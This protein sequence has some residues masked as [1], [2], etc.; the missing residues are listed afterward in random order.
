MRTTAPAWRKTYVVT[1]ST[2]AVGAAVA[3]QLT[4][5]GHDVRGLSRHT[6]ISI[7]DPIALAAAFHGADGAFLMIPFDKKAPNLHQREAEIATELAHAVTIA[8][9]RR[10]V[11]LSG[12]SAHL[13][14]KAGSGMGAAIGEQLLDQIDIPERVYLRA[15]FFM[16]NHLGFGF[17][18]QAA[19]SH[20]YA[21]MFRPDLATPMIAAK[22]VGRVAAA[23]LTEEP[24]TQPRMR[25]LLGARDY[26]MTE[27]TRILGTAVDL[28]RLRYT[29]IPYDQAR[30]SMIDQGLSGSF[31]DAVIETAHSFNDGI[32][33]ATQPQS[34]NN[35]TPTTLE[36][37]ARD[38]VRPVYVTAYPPTTD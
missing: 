38:V 20:T 9:T 26:T 13:G 28:P 36:D 16:E 22:D 1:G 29:Q 6:G 10:V 24:F 18:D 4:R 5:T 34:A 31:A 11:L 8:R 23:L 35:S 12:T 17:V 21:T 37:F 30:R 15:C 14:P 7:D 27:A 25:E 33:W 19:T 3:D 2:G 32:T